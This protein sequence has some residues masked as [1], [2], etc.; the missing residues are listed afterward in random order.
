M[1]VDNDSLTHFAFESPVTPLYPAKQ[2]EQVF[3]VTRH[4][5]R[6]KAIQLGALEQFFSPT[7]DDIKLIV[8]WMP[9]VSPD[10]I[11]FFSDAS[12][13]NVASISFPITTFT[14]NDAFPVAPRIS[15]TAPRI[16]RSP[17]FLSPV[18]Y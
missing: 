4:S 14:T 16:V 17:P 7:T 5:S 11:Y 15:R 10:R 8:L 3:V 13:N 1:P 18:I 12:K 9:S 2:L 6:F